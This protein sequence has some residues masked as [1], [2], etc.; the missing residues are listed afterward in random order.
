[1]YARIATY[2][3][4]N[5]DAADVVD[6][7]RRGML[8]IFQRS[9]GFKRYGIVDT[10]DGMFVSVSLWGSRSDADRA[11]VAAADFVREQLADRII[12]ETNSVGDLSFFEG[13]PS[14]L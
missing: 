2:R 10:R 3:L 4:T 1:M 7:A 12:L 14:S 8:P 6:V 9:P 13:A 5:G 11:V